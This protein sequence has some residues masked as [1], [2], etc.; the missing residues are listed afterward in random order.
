MTNAKPKFQSLLAAPLTTV[1][2]IG[3]A[4]NMMVTEIDGIGVKTNADLAYIDRRV[5]YI[6]ATHIPLYERPAVTDALGRLAERVGKVRS[7]KVTHREMVARMIDDSI[8]AINLQVEKMPMAGN[9]HDTDTHSP[10]GTVQ[11]RE[12]RATG[13]H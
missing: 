4:H 9:G 1:P 7:L 12:Q 5:P 2:K 11:P 3:P 8:R 6:A 10:A 13:G